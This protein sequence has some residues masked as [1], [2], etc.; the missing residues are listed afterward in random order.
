M[1]EK[2]S[3]AGLLK[4]G[5]LCE[6]PLLRLGLGLC[7]AL[8]IASTAIGALGMGVATACVLVLTSLCA[9]LLRNAFSPKMR[10]AAIVIISAAWASVAQI[11]MQACCPELHAS[12]GVY[13]PL[14]AVNSMILCR[15]E[16]FAAQS[17]IR[18]ALVGSLGM[19]IGYIAALTLVGV[20]REL[21]GHGSIFGASICAACDSPVLL[22][23]MPA[24]GLLVCGLLMGIANRLCK[25]EEVSK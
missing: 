24:G 3:C 21:I 13:V 5:I 6:N 2:K 23:A 15:A 12:L 8:A 7:P 17:D 25:K 11:V 20:V 1:A 19:G 14:I 10:M 22:I 18:T 4:N 16:C 9:S